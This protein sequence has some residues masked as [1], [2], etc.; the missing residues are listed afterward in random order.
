MGFYWRSVNLCGFEWVLGEL[1]LVLVEY[2]WILS[3][4][5]IYV[6]WR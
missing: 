1:W 6:E 4:G 3:F 2:G 5:L